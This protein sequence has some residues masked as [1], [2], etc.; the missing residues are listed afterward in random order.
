MVDISNTRFNLSGRISLIIP[1]ERTERQIQLSI[2]R[3]EMIAHEREVVTFED[4][5]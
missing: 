2:I 4:K 5:I 1:T 3:I